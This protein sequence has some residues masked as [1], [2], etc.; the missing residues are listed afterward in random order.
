MFVTSPSVA[1]DILF[2]SFRGNKAT[3]WG[4]ANEK[5]AMRE[6]ESSIKFKVLPAGLFVDENL[7][8]LA[9]S[10]DGVVSDGEGLV[11]IKC[12]YNC[13]DITPEEGVKNK[14]VTFMEVKDGRYKLRR[15]NRY[16]Y[17]VQGQL[18]ICD[19]NYCDFI[20]WSSHGIIIDRIQREKQ[21]WATEMVDKLK[22]FYLN[23][24]LPKIC[25]NTPGYNK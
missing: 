17:Q 14:T 10:P 18:E 3:D 12:P 2:P 16:F 13:R 6:Y 8:F 4:N 5:S 9:A 15:R 25:Q 19:K 11:E 23:F 21:F 20:V 1:D 22:E 24:M 7:P